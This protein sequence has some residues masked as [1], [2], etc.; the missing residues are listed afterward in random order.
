MEKT[1]FDRYGACH[2]FAPV[3]QMTLKKIMRFSLFVFLSMLITSQWISASSLNGQNLEAVK[4]SLSLN[5]ETLI[6]AFQKIE[7]QTSFRFM[8][9]KEDVRHVRSV[10]HS[11]ALVSLDQLLG[12]I[13]IPNGLTYRQVG[14][15]I[16]VMPGTAVQ[17]VGSAVF[18]E[19]P[20]ILPPLKGRVTDE[21]GEGLPGVSILLKGTQQGTTTDGE[22]NFILDVP[23]ENTVL[24]FSFVGYVSQEMVVGTRTLIEVSMKVDEKSLDE[25]V[26]IGYGTAKKGDLTGSVTRVNADLYKTQSMNQVTDMLAGTVAGFNSNQGTSAAGGGSLEVR[27]PTSLSAGTTPLIVVDGAI[28]HGSLRDINPNDIQSV[29]ILK[30]ASSAAIFGSKSA[31]GVIIITTMKGSSDKPTI[32]FSTKLGITNPTLARKPFGPEQYIQFRE[33]YLRTVNPSKPFDFYTHPDKL[34]S[35]MSLDEWRSL[36]PNASSDNVR[37]WM[38]RL[39]LFPIEQENYLAGKTTD[40]YKE[41][42]R[43]GVRQEYD[44]SIGGGKDNINYYWSV[45]YNDNEGVVI[46]DKYK[47]VRSRLNINFKVSDWLDVGANTQFSNRDEGAVLGSMGFYSNSP[48]GRVFDENG[49]LERLPHGHT[50][51]PLLDYFRTDRMKKV[52]S[53][54]SNLFADIRLP[55]GIQYRIS[56]QPRFEFMKDFQFV[57]KDPRVGGVSSDPNS[58]FREE[59]SDFAWMIDNVLSWRKQVGNHHFDVTMLANMEENK[60]WLS[61]QS[62]VNFSPNEGL[63]FHGLQFGSGPSILNNDYRSTADALMA[64]LNYSFRGKY[65]LTASVRRDGY[66]AFGLLNPRA[67]FPALAFAWQ[68]SEEKFFNVPGIDRMKLRVSWGVNGNRDIGMYA[69]LA[70]VGSNI[71]YDGTSQRVG[72]YNSTLS[73]AGLKWEQTESL[74]FGLDL[75]LFGRRIELTADYYNMETSDLLMNRILPR[76]TGFSSVTSNLGILANQGFEMTLNSTNITKPRLSW[77]SSLVFSLNRNKIKRLFG[78]IGN[79]TL[80]GETRTGEVPDYSNHWF[81]GQAIDVVWDYNVLGIWQTNEADQAAKYKMVPG[82][83]KAEDVDGDG[84]YRD[85]ADKKFI[86]HTR[87]RYRLGLRN[88]FEF[89]KHFSASVF[90]RA[91]LGHIGS[92]P[93]ALNVGWESNDR[94]NRNVGPVPYWT[95]QNPIN[96]YARLNVSTSGYGGGL[97]IFRPQSFVRVQDVSLTYAIPSEVSQR[98]RMSNVR[99]FTSARNLLTFTKWPHWDPESNNV[100]MPRIYTLGLNLSL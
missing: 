80:L 14:Q 94:Y 46:G 58:G 8:Y 81:P 35:T 7:K 23:N 37:E 24:V 90:I 85:F 84:V 53:V 38:A 93:N 34:P 66:S 71:W 82:D 43:N 70:Q 22:G 69:A 59:Y 15:R 77:S 36:N 21:K 33:D 26:V 56:Y 100:P 64:R 62:N 47:S 42:I 89:L 16:M 3:S 54:F 50:D 61:R 97:R 13:L 68:L 25:V 63:G 30:D 28:F 12:A 17:E 39:A 5:N 72:V 6:H 67:T 29:D 44:L 73:N 86:G 10:S 45:G 1:V 49:N 31:S 32:T 60:R 9:R 87:P 76:V 51:N 11:G 95:P 65:L 52:N 99:V 98:I 55:F 88:D 96:D 40:W 41:I 78:D 92:Y 27:G 2:H 83:F 20:V 74:N 18:P 48:Y 57:S 75:G 79:Y 4:V 19:I 91:D